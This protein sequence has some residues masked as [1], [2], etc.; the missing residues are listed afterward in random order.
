MVTGRLPFS[1]E[2]QIALVAMHINKPPPSPH[3]L[4]PDLPMRTERVMLKVLAKRPELRYK[5][6]SAFAETFCRSLAAPSETTI[7]SQKTR[8]KIAGVSPY[9]T[10]MAAAS[11]V[12]TSAPVTARPMLS[13][14]STEDQSQTSRDGSFAQAPIYQSQA[15]PAWRKKRSSPARTRG[16]VVGILAL[17]ALLAVIGPMVFILFMVHQ[18][19]LG[20]TTAPSATQTVV[21]QVQSTA[22]T[23]PTATPTPNMTA[24]TQAITATAVQQ[25]QQ[26]TA[27]TIARQTATVQAQASATAGVIQTATAG[28]ATYADA[29]NNASATSTMQANWDQNQGCAF[30][31]SGYHAFARKMFSKGQMWGCMENSYSYTNMTIS[32]DMTM[33][34]GHTGGVFFRINTDLFRNYAGYL[35]ALDSQG[36]Y[37]IARS[38][39]FST[40]NVPVKKGMISSGFKAGYNAKN[41]LQIIANGSSLSFYVNGVFLDQEQDTTFASGTI[42]F[43]ASSADNGTDADIAYSN[44]RVFTI[45]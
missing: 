19:G 15:M 29:L 23:M 37:T 42:A 28:N 25:A 45:S 44:I 30:K 21:T 43:F 20:T 18:N 10:E 12:Q 40:D 38:K 17:L 33:V 31:T 35:F 32:V 11:S 4:V 14:G 41:T 24:T 13:A 27:T 1:A 8:I 22:T 36:N 34:S 3:S 7:S 16:V 6:A 2:S 9:D 39:N 26:A 5:T